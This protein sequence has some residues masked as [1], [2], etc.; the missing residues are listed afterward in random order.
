MKK[1]TKTLL[2]VV[3]IILVCVFAF[4]A[5]KL[6]STLHGYKVADN[7]YSS[8]NNRYVTGKS[9]NDG[10]SDPN[11]D[12]ETSPISVDFDELLQQSSDVVG[13]LYS[14]DTPI[15]YPVVR[16]EDNDYYLHRFLDGSYNPSG[17]LFVE[18]LCEGD[19]SGKNTIIYGHNMNDGSMFASLVKYRDANQEY[20]DEHPVMYLNTP[21]QNYRIDIFAG[22]I[23]DA[24]SSTY[25]IGFGTDEA[26]E[27]YIENVRAQS[28][29]EAPVEVSSEDRIVTLS[30]CSYEYTDARCVI[31]GKLVPIN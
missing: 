16:G 17:T 10:N 13:W 3:C 22:Y 26:F 24:D 30:T 21:E 7:M 14:A 12:M 31:Q 9:A 4:S 15:N 23:T 8:L 1:S 6:I 20:Y 18:V 25:T 5:Y 27:A 19:F 29:F 11:S 2:T 28:L